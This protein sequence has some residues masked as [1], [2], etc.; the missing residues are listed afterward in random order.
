MCVYMYS[1]IY[2]SICLTVYLSIYM[3]IYIPSSLRS[4]K[5]R[6]CRSAVLS[7]DRPSTLFNSLL[8]LAPCK[9]TRGPFT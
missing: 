2:P 5:F 1:S 4:S 7:T 9:K 3:Y 8:D 6:S